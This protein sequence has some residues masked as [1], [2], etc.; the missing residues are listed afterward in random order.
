MRSRLPPQSIAA[1]RREPSCEARIEQAAQLR[2]QVAVPF[3]LHG[4]PRTVTT[5]ICLLQPVSE[6]CRSASIMG[7]NWGDKSPVTVTAVP[8]PRFRQ[9][10]WSRLGFHLEHSGSP[11][12]A[13]WLT[14]PPPEDLPGRLWSRRSGTGRFSLFRAPKEEVLV[15]EN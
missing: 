2:P 6:F 7:P 10:Q 12:V 4:W 3:P 9:A 14:L 11:P 5:F 13:R 8:G 1:V 15:Q